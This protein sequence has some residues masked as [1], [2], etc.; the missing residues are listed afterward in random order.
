MSAKW[1]LREQRLFFG[2][3]RFEHALGDVEARATINR[4]LQ[5]EIE[6]L[7]FG[8]TL[9]DSIG[10]LEERL[11]LLVAAKIQ[12]LAVRALHTLEIERHAR[13][14]LFLAAPVALA[15]GHG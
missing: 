9:D 12:I 14:L 2:R 10:A 6:F 3:E 8:N 4:F 7:R 15:H 1:A 11:Q 5:Y 13:K